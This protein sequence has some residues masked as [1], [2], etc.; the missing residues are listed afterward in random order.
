MRETKSLFDAVKLGALELRNRVVMAPMTRS[1]AGRG[2]VPTVMQASYYAQ[3]ASAGLIVAEGTQPSPAG[4]GYCRTPGLYSDEQVEGWRSVSNA[5]HEAGG[6][7]VVQLMHCGRVAARINKA[8][9]SEIVA[10]SALRA[11]ADIF[12]DSAGMVPMDMPR[13][14]ATEE[15]PGVIQEYAQAA[16]NAR[17]AGLDGVELHCASGYLPMQFLSTGTNRRTDRYG[18]SV[19]N[20]IR[21]VIEVL[22]AMSARIGS[23]RVGFR[24]CPGFPY[25]DISD[26][27]P[28]ETYGALLG[29]ASGLGLAYLHLIMLDLPQVDGLGVVREHWRGA[30]ILNNELDR[31][32]AEHLIE[33]GAEAIS[34]GRSFI[35]NPD[36]VGRL[37][38]NSPLA[39]F[40]PAK[41]YTPGPA[42]YIDYAPLTGEQVN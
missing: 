10:P 6:K 30:V 25:N 9:D 27:N 22:E 8:D 13:A 14:L 42:G 21:F 19:A 4:K 20:R 16:M 40:D 7:I 26:E 3:R 37:K 33:Q 12:T 15:I 41:L 5:V 34:F 28:A 35:A 2:D 18:G 38:S 36:L 23:D 1:R 24:I 11:G 32:K 17:K 39:V 31:T 29:A